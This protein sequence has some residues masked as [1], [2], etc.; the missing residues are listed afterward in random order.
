M[1]KTPI[2]SIII[3]NYNVRQLLKGCLQSL[4]DTF[5]QENVEIIVVDNHSTD[6]SA[7]MLRKEFPQVKVIEN[8][9][10]RG[11][12]A[13]NNQGL[14]QSQGEYI[15]LLNP[16]T[17]VLP[18]ALREMVNFIEIHSDAGALGC[19]I[20]NADGTLQSSCRNFPSLTTIFLE[21]TGLYRLLSVSKRLR[22][23]YLILWDHDQIRAVDSVK[24]ACL[25]VR[26]DVI[27][28]IGFLDEAFFLY[29]EEVDLCKRISD[30]GWNIYFTPDAQIVHYDKQSSRLHVQRN[31]AQQYKARLLYYQKHL[32]KHQAFL[33]RLLVILG[34]VLRLMTGLPLFLAGDKYR[35]YAQAREKALWNTFRSLLDRS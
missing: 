3:V 32:N 30:A 14:R 26:K 34:V 20:L 12:A 8:E 4:E 25:M 13:A 10:N 28:Q 35:K 11:F 2:L 24:G 1:N 27:D 29:G 7:A 22:N 5:P 31:L 17:V 21:N 18:N 23:R 15:L 16:D 6:K 19:K 33:G 9:T